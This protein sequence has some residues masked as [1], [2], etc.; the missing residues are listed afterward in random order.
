MEE[1][2]RASEDRFRSIL[3]NIEDGYY[4][5]DTAGNLTFLNPALTRLFGRSANEMI[6]MNNRQFMPPEQAK[7]VFQTYNRVF[8]TG[9]PEQAFN[10]DVARQDGTLRSVES[11]VSLI[12]TADGSVTGFRGTVRDITD[13]KKAEETLQRRNEYL[14]ATAEIG[15]LVTSTLDMPTLFSRTVNLV[16]DRFGFY[17]AGIFVTEETG[18]QAILQA[19]T[20]EAGAEM[21]RQKHSLQ[22]GSKSVV[23]G[24]TESGRAVVVNDTAASE[25][26]KFN[27]L[28]PETRAEAALPLRVGSR[29]IGAL[30][31]QSTQ[32]NAFSED[33]IAVLQS[34]A[35]Q[36]AIAIDNARSYELSMQAVKEMREADRLKSQFLANMSHELRTPLNS[37][38]GFS[39][40]ILKGID[41]ATT[42]LQQQDLLAIHNSGQH[43]LGLINDI[44]DLSRI[45]AGKME[46][47][48]DEV[49]LAELTS[50]VMST[51]TGLFKDKPIT[52]HRDLPADLPTVRADAMRI[53]QVLLNL[54]SNAAKFTDEGSI[55]VQAS[56]KDSPTGHPEVTVSVTDTGPGIASEDQKKLFQPFSQVDASPTRKSG[57]SGLGLS[58]S[59]H[60]IQMHGGRI[61]VESAPG[62]GSTF[63]FTLPA[64]RG[65]TEL[66]TPPGNRIILAIDDDPQVVSLYERYLQPQ[67]YQVVPLGDPS[68]AVERVRQLKPFAITLDIMMPGYDG[69][70]VLNDLKSN[71]ETRDIPVIVCSIVEEREKGFSL[72]AADYLVKPILEDDIL[73][74]LDRLNVDGSI[75]EVLIV[76]DDPND[77]RLIG[78]MLSENGRYRP[79]LAEGGRNGWEAVQARTPHALILD[80]FMPE[81]DGFTLLE[82]MRSSEKLREVP[83]I[84][85]SGG[86]LTLEQQKMLQDFGQRMIQKSALNEQQLLSTLE[87]AL[88][89]VKH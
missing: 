86:D 48:F 67:G 28:L 59:N 54:L 9:I 30:D 50:S 35:D 51:I 70:R 4:E 76:D 14:F 39:R 23:G 26:H 12:K 82:K 15:R 87:R 84:V 22:V 3:D 32:V 53:R 45:E 43:L 79:I 24:V 73:N 42:D 60:L 27:P 2:L 63:F 19:A 16:R 10:W 77:L 55:T 71:P 66:G 31:I 44:L 64:F 88:E 17:H 49:N 5:V 75:R 1:V 69:W 11:S 37:I 41:G 74:V 6:G 81:M 25:S 85:V 47:T 61:G 62:R 18:F 68:R 7:T 56:V 36:I 21:L 13:R 38:I 34:L 40:V 58:I 65:K 20:G 33:D 29:T 57:G 83:V 52:L 80:L 46:L 78:R 89:R 8:R 72:G